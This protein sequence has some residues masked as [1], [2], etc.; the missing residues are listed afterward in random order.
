MLRRLFTCGLV[1]V[2]AT[3]LAPTKLLGQSNPLSRVAEDDY[4]DHDQLDR[5]FYMNPAVQQWF[6]QQRAQ[7][8]GHPG[9]GQPGYPQPS[10]G[11]QGLAQQQQASAQQQAYAQQIQQQQMIQRL[12]LMRALMAQQQMQQAY[13]QQ[14][15]YYGGGYG[16]G[17]STYLGGG[18]GYGGGI[19]SYN[20]IT[21]SGGSVI[22]DRESG[23]GQYF[24]P[25]G[26]RAK[27][28]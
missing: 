2:G 14:Q 13:Q 26:Y 20:V 22:V 5:G 8:S 6:A 11:Q 17:S 3:V 1:V 10:Y 15:G 7:Q 25:G 27:H 24:E 9:F 4:N 28:D 21:D 19:G 18:A 16:G 12:I 23:V